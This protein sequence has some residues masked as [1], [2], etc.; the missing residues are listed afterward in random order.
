M[1]FA[2]RVSEAHIVLFA[3]AA[4]VA[5]CVMIAYMPIAIIREVNRSPDEVLPEW[6]GTVQGRRTRL[7]VVLAV[8]GTLAIGGLAAAAFG[9]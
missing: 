4:F 5:L 1:V 9:L 7:R 2:A 6:M 8:F 3:V